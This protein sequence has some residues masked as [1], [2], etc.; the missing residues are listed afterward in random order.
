M[1]RYRGQK[2]LYEVIGGRARNKA[3]RPEV[4][5][6]RP[7]TKQVEKPVTRKVP[8]K[9]QAQR[10]ESAVIPEKKAISWKP[11]PIQCHDGRI[12]VTLSTKAAAMAS[13]CLVAVLLACFRV[14]QWYPDSNIGKLIDNKNSV[15]PDRTGLTSLARP[16]R[17]VPV[18]TGSAESRIRQPIDP[19]PQSAL[20]TPAPRNAIVIQEFH[21]LEDLVGV[22]RFFRSKGILTDI[23]SKEGVYYLITQQRFPYNPASTLHTTGNEL[24]EEIRL[25]GQ[26]YKASQGLESFAPNKF[27]GAY[28]RN[29]DDQYIGEVTD[30]R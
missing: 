17:N 4:E 9:V 2:A 24:L 5:H 25:L 20:G 29:I 30:V 16:N 19:A 22:G 3:A 14:G 18:E 1:A 8:V 10:K 7:E 11:K 28:G 21:T 27:K 12:E 6:L 15:S 13:L 26:E 23:V